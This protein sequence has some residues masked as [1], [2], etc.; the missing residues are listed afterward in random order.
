FEESFGMAQSK[1]SYHLSKLK[2]AGLVRE[3]KR[4]KWSFY[5]L[6]RDVFDALLAETGG[7]VGISWDKDA[8]F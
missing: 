8:T 4:G 5:S 7:H 3:E 1:V 2:E 6:N